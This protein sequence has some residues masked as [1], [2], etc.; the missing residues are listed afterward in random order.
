[1][2]WSCQP[3]CL[4]RPG[5]RAWAACA[6]EETGSVVAGSSCRLLGVLFGRR[7]SCRRT[8]GVEQTQAS[9]S[10][11][12]SGGAVSQSRPAAK[13]DVHTSI[14][15][16]DPRLGDFLDACSE[17]R[18]VPGDGSIQIRRGRHLHD[19]ERVALTASKPLHQ[20]GTRSLRCEGLRAFL[21][22]PPAASPCR[23]SD[24]PTPPNFLRQT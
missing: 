15:V 10:P 23:G 14:T 18:R 1:M 2:C 8:R 4:T 6:P 19:P 16:V 7:T 5:P 11:C 3:R 24:G 13:Q 22:P 21:R 17:H 20:L 12:G 9:D